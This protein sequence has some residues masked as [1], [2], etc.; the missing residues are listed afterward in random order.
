MNY[1]IYIY[2]EDSD[3]EDNNNKGNNS[4]DNN[5]KYNDNKD[6]NNEDYGQGLNSY[7]LLC[8]VYGYKYFDKML[9]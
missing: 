3:N 7:S 4:E 1:V 5:N 9:Q 2:N 6:N 8:L